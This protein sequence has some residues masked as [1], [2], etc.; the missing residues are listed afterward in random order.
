PARRLR[1]RLSL[2]WSSA[3]ELADDQKGSKQSANG[4]RNGG[5]IWK[6]RRK[7]KAKPHGGCHS[8]ARRYG[9]SSGKPRPLL[10]SEFRRC[11]A[12]NGRPYSG[13]TEAIQRSRRKPE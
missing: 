6:A 7:D 12:E 8:R 5:G 13:S 11:H 2:D 1:A 9:H 10:F 4:D 3:R